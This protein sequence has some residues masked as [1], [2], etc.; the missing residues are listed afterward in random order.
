[1]RATNLVPLLILVLAFSCGDDHSTNDGGIDSGTAGSDFAA[2]SSGIDLAISGDGGQ[3]CPAAAPQ[4]ACANP[5]GGQVAG[6]Q[7]TI[8]GQGTATVTV[9]QGSQNAII[10][11]NTFNIGAGET[12]QFIQPNAGAVALNRRTAP[13][14]Q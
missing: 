7:A 13:E 6:G 3:S 10:N 5:L 1:M 14:L 2:P 12:T 4:G 11:W 8:Q 9:T